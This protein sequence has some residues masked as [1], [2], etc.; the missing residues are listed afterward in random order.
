MRRLM[1]AALAMLTLSIVV[2]GCGQ[3]GP[4]KYHVAGTVSL[5]KKAL[6]N[7]T[8]IFYPTTGGGDAD[9]A[10]IR[11]GEYACEVK[12]GPKRVEITAQRPM[13]PEKLGPMGGPNMEQYL[14]QKYNKKSELTAEIKASGTNKVDFALESAKP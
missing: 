10:T 5:D 12:P 6:E 4:Q 11:K 3:K 14:P 2:V 9:V 13:V 1:C 8:L 7:G